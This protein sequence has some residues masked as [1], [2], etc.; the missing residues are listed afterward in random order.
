MHAFYHAATVNNCLLPGVVVGADNAE[1]QGKYPAFNEFPAQ[2]IAEQM[3]MQF[4]S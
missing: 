2:Y 4:I 1:I 3:L